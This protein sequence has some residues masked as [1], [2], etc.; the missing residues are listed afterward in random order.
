MALAVLAAASGARAATLTVTS[1]KDSGHG[2]LR[3]AIANA[4][5][6]DKITFRVKGTIKLT[7]GALMITKDLDIEGPG[8]CMRD[9][10]KCKGHDGRDSD[11]LTISGN[12]AS[13]VFVILS[14]DPTSPPKVTIAGVMISDGLANGSSPIFPSTGG[15]ILNL[16]SLILSDD[17]VSNN[18][19][20]G[21]PGAALFGLFV[22]IGDGGGVGS[23]GTLAVTSCLFTGNL[24]RGGDTSIGALA[25][26]L[27]LGGA[28]ANYANMQ[29]TGSQFVGNVA[30]GGSGCGTADAVEAGVAHAGAVA[31][32]GTM[33]ITASTFSHN[34]GIGGNH[35]SGVSGGNAFGGTIASGELFGPVSLE[36]S[37]SQFDHNQAIG[38]N[39]DLGGPVFSNGSA[40]GAGYGAA[41]H[42]WGGPGTISG[43]TLDH[44]E[45]L[46][47]AGGPGAPGGFG[48]GA[49]INIEG[50]S[51][52]TVADCTVEHNMALG[53]AGGVGGNG[54]AGLG[55]GLRSG[56]GTLTV[57]NTTVAHNHAQ[58]GQGNAGGQGGDGQ[59]GGLQTF[60]GSLILKGA[61]VT[62]N[63]A[64][65]GRPGGQG[66]G[67]GVYNAGTFTF[68]ATTV[69][70]KNHASTSGDNVGP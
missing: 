41:F 40:S 26:G 58:G 21:D 8:P 22:G 6:G 16:A 20:L 24:A 33:T 60:G 56:G 64:L 49:A 67:G 59:G 3:E 4:A 30:Q 18:Q 7:S 51:E 50:T 39:D 53:G 38:G 68:D 10:D 57:I 35:N 69:I 14:P 2:S 65:G 15:G 54:A 19:A 9:R 66:I 42:F 46:G 63:L 47:G 13:R 62:D 37:D 11:G 45:A 70:A 27:G 31:N 28:L 52:V 43:C 36:V 17:V 32:V 55:G 44:N 12:H 5:A 48:F 23:F 61:I 29:V 25:P 34:Q 1:L